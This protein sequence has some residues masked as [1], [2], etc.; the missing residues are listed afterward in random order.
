ML[1]VF[2]LPCQLFRKEL[3]SD[4][5]MNQIYIYLDNRTLPKKVPSLFTHVFSKVKKKRSVGCCF[6]SKIEER[7]EKKEGE[8]EEEENEKRR[9]DCLSTW[10]VDLYFRRRR[11][12]RDIFL[13][14][15]S[16]PCPLPC[17]WCGVWGRTFHR[18]VTVTC[19][20]LPLSCFCDNL[21]LPLGMKI[22]KFETLSRGFSLWI[23]G[24]TTRCVSACCG[25]IVFVK[26][27][28]SS[29][30]GSLWFDIVAA[31]WW[32]KTLFEWWWWW[33]W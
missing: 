15:L 7:G 26:M 4:T 16:P 2:N 13:T 25:Y 12:K 27:R 23:H 33:W 17:M 3:S 19:V 24:I 28:S 20:P 6:D 1:L 8:E 29:K 32:S 18:V 5:K 14:L 31:W 9:I 21:P 10:K 22:R 11:R 30:L